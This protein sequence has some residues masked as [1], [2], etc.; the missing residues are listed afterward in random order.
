ME[1]F[2]GLIYADVK[3]IMSSHSNYVFNK[4]NN[5]I[6]GGV[7]DYNV[8]QPIVLVDSESGSTS[9]ILQMDELG[10]DDENFIDVSE[11][12]YEE[13]EEIIQRLNMEE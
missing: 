8:Y 13:R 3:L 2:A 4:L 9:K 12:L 11:K 7:L 6:L 5:L 1:I 10:A